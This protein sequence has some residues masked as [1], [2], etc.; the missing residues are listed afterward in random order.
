[1]KRRR[2]SLLEDMEEASQEVEARSQVMFP[3]LRTLQVQTY[4]WHFEII[5]ELDVSQTHS[6]LSD[7]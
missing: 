2:S 7:P 5:D 1:M 6:A 4:L 3:A